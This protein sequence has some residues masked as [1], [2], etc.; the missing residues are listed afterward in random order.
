MSQQITSLQEQVET[1]FANLNGLRS[2]LA[3][4]QP[5]IDPSLQQHSLMGPRGTAS[6]SSSQP[7]PGMLAPRIRAPSQSKPRQPTFVGP[8]SSHF[9]LGVAK[10]SLQSMGIAAN[11]DPL[12][13]IDTTD[14][15][16]SGSPPPDVP[17]HPSKDPIW[18]IS[19]EEAIRLVGIY[20]DETYDMYPTVYIPHVLDHLNSLYTWM[21]AAV[22]NGFVQTHMPGPDSID[23]EDTKILKLI[24]A[25]GLIVEGC[26]KSDLGKRMYRYVQPSVDALLLGHAGFKGIRMLSIAVCLP[27]YSVLVP[28]LIK[29]AGNVRVPLRQRG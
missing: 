11:E 25:T 28:L 15:S 10:S 5:Q 18:L 23:D 21:E 13:A 3:N 27:T 24:L 16:P 7:S 2:D 29:Y 22:R 26:G 4:S 12:T 20:E 8:T 14:V 9:N 19:R 17:F 6:L 1:L